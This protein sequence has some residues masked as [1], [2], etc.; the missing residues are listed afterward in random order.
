MLQQIGFHD[1]SRDPSS[2]DILRYIIGDVVGILRRQRALFLCLAIAPGP[3]CDCIL[4]FHYA[5]L[6]S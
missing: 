1:L 3:E 5:I 6:Y 2:R 4:I